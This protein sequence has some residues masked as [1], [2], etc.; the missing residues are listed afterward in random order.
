MPPKGRA[1]DQNDLK[2]QVLALQEELA[3]LRNTPAPERD[4]TVLNQARLPPIPLID[5]KLNGKPTYR[6]W[7]I[8]IEA[9][10]QS[11]EYIWE[12]IRDGTKNAPAS[13]Q[14]YARSL[15][16]LNMVPNLQMETRH[17]ASAHEI[18]IHWKE[19]FEANEFADLTMRVRRLRNILW[20]QKDDIEDFYQE[21]KGTQMT[22]QEVSG[23][24][25]PDLVLISLLLCAIDKHYSDFVSSVEIQLSQ[26]ATPAAQKTF[27]YIFGRFRTEY[28]RKKA[29]EEEQS[30]DEIDGINSVQKG[31]HCTICDRIHGRNCWV[32]D[33]ELGP[34]YLRDRLQKRHDEWKAKTNAKEEGLT[35]G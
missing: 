8:A 26:P 18:W 25:L 28:Y 6:T 19:Q 14:Q 17:K 9:V 31:H 22:V 16:L 2:A 10:A 20:N 4:N 30:E 7:S 11:I 12:I 23:Q 24:P 5:P 33:P 3:L 29:R 15:L 32:K 21:F 1:D 34:P 27:E 13:H 35:I